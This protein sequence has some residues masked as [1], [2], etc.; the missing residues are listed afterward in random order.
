MAAIELRDAVRRLPARSVLALTVWG[1]ARGESTRGQVAV[2]WVVKNRA[3]ARRQT[4]PHVCLDRWQFSCWWGQDPNA[5]ALRLR[6]ER[7]LAGQ[8]LP[9]PRWL[10]ILQLSHQVL[11]GGLADPTGGADHYL[12]T[13]LHQDDDCPLWAKSMTVAT[14][15]GRHV[16]LQD[17]PESRDR[18]A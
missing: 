14:T 13:I 16:F 12:T 6:A 5:Q 2:A 1:E 8:V 10:A 11:V 3:A 18:R 4:I 15:I 9:E 7:V 17:R